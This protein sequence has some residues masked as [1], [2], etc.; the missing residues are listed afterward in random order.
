MELSKRE[1]KI[2]R[3]L[4]EKGLREELKRGMSSFD[5]ILQQW[6][7]ESGDVKEYYYQIFGAV[8]DFDK[9]IAWRYD[10]LRGSRY[11]D[12]IAGQIID[13]LY[14]QSELDGF[15]QEIKE[16]IFRMTNRQL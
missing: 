12:T 11:I 13:K 5:A 9:Q 10:G 14:D 7:A 6:K 3:E 16:V 1:K 4:I 2:A 8:K 15:S